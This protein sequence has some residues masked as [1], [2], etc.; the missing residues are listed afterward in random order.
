MET[1]RRFTVADGREPLARCLEWV[2]ERTDAGDASFLVFSH[3]DTEHSR[4]FLA[5]AAHVLPT[6]FATLGDMHYHEVITGPVHGYADIDVDAAVVTDAARRFDVFV[7]TLEV[8][9]RRAFPT[10]V[11]VDVTIVDASIPGTKFSRHLH[12]QMRRANGEVVVFANATHVRDFMQHVQRRANVGALIDAGVYRKRGSLRTVY[13]TKMADLARPLL[14]LTGERTRDFGVFARTL[15]TYQ[16][17]MDP[18]RWLRYVAATTATAAATTTPFI[19]APRVLT[20][21]DTQALM[22]QARA[23]VP[24]LQTYTP[25]SVALRDA[26]ASATFDV[27]CKSHVCGA[28]GV[29]HR[30]LTIYF[31]VDVAR[32]RYRQNCFSK[33]RVKHLTWVYAADAAAAAATPL[34]APARTCATELKPLFAGVKR[35]RA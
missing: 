31:T 13:S 8:E 32:R 20:D 21:R 9:A 29:T 16:T 4:S 3:E 18:R 33:K 11:A 30:Q 14:P 34:P 26:G 27:R 1:C 7:K 10:V 23:I 22:A 15:A 19:Q 5:V 35:A 12:T 2:R 25:F 17:T 6:W 28:C 24:H